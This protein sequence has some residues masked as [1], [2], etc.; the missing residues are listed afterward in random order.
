MKHIS[1]IILILIVA[2][3]PSNSQDDSNSDEITQT[4]GDNIY[5]ESQPYQ[6]PVSLELDHSTDVFDHIYY[7]K[8]YNSGFEIIDTMYFE[9]VNDSVIVKNGIFNMWIQ[10]IDQ[11][12]IGPFT[13][14]IDTGLVFIEPATYDSIYQ[15]RRTD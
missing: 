9:P 4:G 12:S 10:D 3:S 13:R 6:I 1:L 15:F 7:L 8:Y 11:G 5:N 14:L 2:C